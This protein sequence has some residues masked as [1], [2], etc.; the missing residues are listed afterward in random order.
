MTRDDAVALA[1]KHIDAAHPGKHPGFM[2][3]EWVIA[4]IMEAAGAEYI[5]PAPRWTA[6]MF[7]TQ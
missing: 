2:P 7:E 6:D 4:S 1:C 3:M 5:E